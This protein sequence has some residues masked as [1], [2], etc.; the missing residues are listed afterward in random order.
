LSHGFGAFDTSNDIG[1][2]KT[3]QIGDVDDLFHDVKVFDSNFNIDDISDLFRSVEVLQ[4]VDIDDI[5]HLYLHIIYLQ[6]PYV[7]VPYVYFLDDH[8]KVCNCS[9]VVVHLSHV[10]YYYIFQN[11]DIF[12]QDF[13][14]SV[15]FFVSIL[16]FIF[17]HFHYFMIK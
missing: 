3:F 15:I 17:F 1:G 13:H 11:H 2:V 14:Y 6:V 4:I 10:F 16:F 9:Y 8:I 5:S 12:Y 7:Y